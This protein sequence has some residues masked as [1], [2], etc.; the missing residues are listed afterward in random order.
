MPLVKKIMFIIAI[1]LVL[2]IGMFFAVIWHYFL[3]A[4]MTENH[5]STTL[6]VPSG[7]GVDRLATELKHRGFLSHPRLFISIAALRGDNNKLKAGEYEIKPGMSAFQLLDNIVAGK[8][9]LRSITLIEGKTFEEIKQVLNNNPYL[10]HQITGLNNTQIMQ[11]MGLPD[12]S[13]E[14]LFFPSTYFFTWGD[15]DFMILKKSYNHMQKLLTSVWEQRSTDLP[16]QNAY[17][18]LIV[19][20]L[21]EKETALA[22]ERPQIA[23]VI[24]RRLQKKMMLQVDP[25]VLYGLG[26][27][28]GT[29]ITRANLAVDTP[30]NTY[31]HYG[32]PPTP[33]AMPSRASIV[34]ALHPQTGD[35]LYYVSRGD[36]SHI[37]SVNYTAHREAIAKYLA[38]SE[39]GPPLVMKKLLWP[40]CVTQ[41]PLKRQ[42]RCQ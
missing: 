24:L 32:L 35:E 31:R 22:K 21:I 34:A 4:P 10:L 8:V 19:A 7:T 16:Y 2:I 26:L 40:Y 15:S 25:T 41:V 5:S 20:S 38:K 3:R 42:K 11:Q 27:P 6:L 23:G 36:G 37:F 30:Y 13:P 12:Q 14:G 29:P 33:I 1:I 18:V 9:Y 39:M 28:Y 17:Q